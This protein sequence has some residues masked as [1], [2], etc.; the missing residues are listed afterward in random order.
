MI[1]SIYLYFIYKNKYVK[2]LSAV[3]CCQLCSSPHI[4]GCSSPTR[5]CSSPEEECSSP[6]TGG[7]SS[8]TCGEKEEKKEDEKKK[9]EEDEKEEGG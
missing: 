3:H 8:P 4:G 9:V 7:C 6:H 1:R 5:G 2:E